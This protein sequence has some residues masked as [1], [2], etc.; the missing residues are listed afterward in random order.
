MINKY[1]EGGNETGTQKSRFASVNESTDWSQ[2]VV[3]HPW[4]ESTVSTILFHVCEEK[5]FKR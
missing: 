2:L 5:S 1:L 3:E 4:L